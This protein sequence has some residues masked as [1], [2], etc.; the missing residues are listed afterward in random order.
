MKIREYYVYQQ[1]PSGGISYDTT[2]EFKKD[3]SI[4]PFNSVFF[5]DKCKSKY[6]NIA[7]SEDFKGVE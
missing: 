7:V 4:L 1:T 2:E 5:Y 3:L 6:H